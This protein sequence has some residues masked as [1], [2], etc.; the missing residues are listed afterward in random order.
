MRRFLTAALV[1]A[2]SLFAAAL[3]ANDSPEA[4]KAPMAKKIVK[5]TDIHGEK[6]EDD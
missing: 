1:G 4:S 2:T 3:G 5:M 6:L